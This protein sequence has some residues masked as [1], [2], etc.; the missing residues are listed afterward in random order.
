MNRGVHVN[1]I[2]EA[3]LVPGVTGQ[4]LADGIAAGTRFLRS[5]EGL[6][7]RQSAQSDNTFADI[8]EWRDEASAQ[9]ALAAS[10][11]C[12]GCAAFFARFDME[13]VRMRHFDFVE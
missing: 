13:S 12:A 4:Q 5:C 7:R 1:E 10:E 8:V 9:R 11:T 2:A 6:V 3:E